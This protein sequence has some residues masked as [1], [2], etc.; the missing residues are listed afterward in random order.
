M[1]TLPRQLLRSWGLQ[2]S[3]ADPL[4]AA[5]LLQPE[6]MVHHSKIKHRHVAVELNPG[7]PTHGQTVVDHMGY[8][9][10]EATTWVMASMRHEVLDRLM[11]IAY[12]DTA[13]AHK[14]VAQLEKDIQVVQ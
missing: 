1:P 2:F 6:R 14:A 13:D 11:R 7:S 3:T 4:A 5:I 12:M 8:S 9:C 10:Q